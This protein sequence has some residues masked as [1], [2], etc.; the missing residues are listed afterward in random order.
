MT[1][2]KRYLRTIASFLV[3]LLLA[4]EALEAARRKRP[5]SRKSVAGKTVRPGKARP[6]RSVARRAQKRTGPQSAAQKPRPV[7]PETRPRVEPEPRIQPAPVVHVPVEPVPASSVAFRPAAFAAPV[8]V[9]DWDYGTPKLQPKPQVQYPILRAVDR[10]N[11]EPLVLLA[12]GAT[13]APGAAPRPVDPPKPAASPAP[14]RPKYVPVPL[15]LGLIGGGQLRDLFKTTLGPT[16]SL[17]DTSGRIVVGPTI[18][19][20]WDRYAVQLDAL[21]RGYG[22]RSSGNLLGLGFS[23]RST[24]RTWEFPLL[25]KRKFNSPEMAFRPFI[26]A[27]IAMRYL[28]Q[29]STI[30]ANDQSATEQTSTRQMTFGLPLA[31][32]M[33]FHLHRF[34]L[35]PELRYTLWTADN[36]TPIR[37]QLFD[38]NYNQFQLLF[39]FTF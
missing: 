36:A 16:N 35:S 10:P 34:R 3:L 32:G 17:E 14:A 38:P 7:Q 5:A 29:T 13:P 37:T 20:H 15:A 33:E 28:G 24:G 9:A 1:S 21:Y 11:F 12:Q 39:G 18:Q 25:L 31:L 26:G 22:L 27:G 30:S 2:P 8:P 23:N 19:F 6:R 4:P